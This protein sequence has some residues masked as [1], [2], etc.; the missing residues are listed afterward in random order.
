LLAAL[1]VV[2]VG[3]AVSASSI[4]AYE[5]DARTIALA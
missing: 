2:T 3:F 4:A 1:I 5:Y